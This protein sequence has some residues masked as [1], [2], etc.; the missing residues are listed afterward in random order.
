MRDIYRKV[1][2]QV[3]I[4]C[5]RLESE[6]FYLCYR[7]LKK[8]H[9]GTIVV[10]QFFRFAKPESRFILRGLYCV[11][12]ILCSSKSNFKLKRRLGARAV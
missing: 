11:K 6:T 4:R 10:H 2:S 1:F 3:V 9:F 5:V 12:E 8:S 7:T